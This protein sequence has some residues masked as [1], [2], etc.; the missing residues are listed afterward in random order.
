L[1]D[2][3]DDDDDLI[4][5]IFAKVDFFLYKAAEPQ[6]THSPTRVLLLFF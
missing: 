1:I 6:L 3:D 5:G 4:N 2:D